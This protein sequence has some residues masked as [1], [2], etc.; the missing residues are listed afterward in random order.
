MSCFLF[1]L[2]CRVVV[3]V[4]LHLA[5]WLLGIKLI[6]QNNKPR[7]ALRA[8]PNYIIKQVNFTG[9]QSTIPLHAILIPYYRDFEN[10]KCIYDRGHSSFSPDQKVVSQ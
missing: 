8:I 2:I 7:Q 1:D 4:C 5:R 10:G 9:Y 6:I 3:V